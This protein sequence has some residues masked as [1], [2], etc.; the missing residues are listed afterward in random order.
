MT[1]TNITYHLIIESCHEDQQEYVLQ[2]VWMII[3]V[4]S[5]WKKWALIRS[6]LGKI[7]RRARYKS[8]VRYWIAQL[9]VSTIS[10][11]RADS[12]NFRFVRIILSFRIFDDVGLKNWIRDVVTPIVVVLLEVWRDVHVRICVSL[13]DFGRIYVCSPF[14]FFIKR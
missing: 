9:R 3:V 7:R 12:N 1:K 11:T 5:L 4:F 8:E 14:L 2:W 6:A 13:C 10:G